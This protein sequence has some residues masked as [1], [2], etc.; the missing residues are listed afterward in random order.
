MENIKS[1]IV[2]REQGIN[3]LKRWCNQPIIKVISG[4]RRS[5]KSTLFDIFRTQLLD[6]GISEEQIQTINFEDIK[7]HEL[8]DPK[9][10]HKYILENMVVDAMNYIFLDEIQYVEEFEKVI[11]S[12]LLIKNTDL[13]ITGSN[14]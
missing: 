12:L 1:K 11:N 7:N 2:N 14:A 10:L 6:D 13:Y 9:L 4:V 3:F 5:G 8:T